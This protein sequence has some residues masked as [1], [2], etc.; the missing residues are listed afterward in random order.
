[1]SPLK[2]N[3]GIMLS[4]FCVQLET[5]ASNMAQLMAKKGATLLWFDKA[6]L[7]TSSSTGSKRA[8][9]ICLITGPRLAPPISL[10]NKAI[11]ESWNLLYG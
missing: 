3:P 1:M 7:R 10:N 11:L 5:G 2:Y 4:N 9:G 6:L 8:G